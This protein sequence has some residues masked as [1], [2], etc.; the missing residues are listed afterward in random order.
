L[1][2]FV[3]VHSS[4]GEHGIPTFKIIPSIRGAVEDVSAQVLAIFAQGFVGENQDSGC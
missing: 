2:G 3:E 4:G 1:S